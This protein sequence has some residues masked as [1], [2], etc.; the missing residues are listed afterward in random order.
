[1]FCN[2]DGV[3]LDKNVII[4]MADANNLIGKRPD[5]DGVAY[6]DSDP[7]FVLDPQ[8]RNGSEWKEA[9][10]YLGFIGKTLDEI[11]AIKPE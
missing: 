7:D 10:Y 1:M 3:T 2:P 4:K 6:R 11:I 8:T 5:R 9:N